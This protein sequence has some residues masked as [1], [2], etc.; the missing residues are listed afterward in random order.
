MTKTVLFCFSLDCLDNY[1]WKQC[2]M[3]SGFIKR[4]F[5]RFACSKHDFCFTSLLK[6]C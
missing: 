6:N 1:F 4:L 3:V 2:T 5:S